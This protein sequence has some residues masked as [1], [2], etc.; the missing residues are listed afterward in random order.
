VD[1]RVFTE[2]ESRYLDSLKYILNYGAK[3]EDR[4]GTGTVGV[5]GTQT[6]YELRTTFPLLTTKKVY[7]NG[8]LHELLWFLKGDTNIKYLHDHNVHIRDEWADKD[9]N[10]GPVYGAQWR[11]WSHGRDF[12]VDQIQNL[13]AGIKKNPYSRR[14]IVSAWNVAEVDNM[15][16]PP[17]HVMFQFYVQADTLSCQ[18]YQRSADMFLG[19]PFN[20]ASY[21]LLTHIVAKECGLRPWQFIHTIGDAHIYLNHV[22]QVKEQLSREMKR[23]PNLEISDDWPGIFNLTGQEFTVHNYDPHP[24]IKAPVAV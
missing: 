24:A 13:I 6:R 21:S 18:L 20:I 22:D 17:C 1:P 11:G 10:L 8:V 9:G 4:T 3:R 14:H 5:F 7:W 12:S 23:G 19:V 2:N 16:L 15:A